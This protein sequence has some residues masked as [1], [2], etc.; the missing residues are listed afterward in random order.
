MSHM[1]AFFGQPPESWWWWKLMSVF[2]SKFVPELPMTWS[3]V[4]CF[5][6]PSSQLLWT[7]LT[8]VDCWSITR[9]IHVDPDA[10]EEFQH[11]EQAEH[12][13]LYLQT[14]QMQS[15]MV[16]F[17]DR[18]LIFPVFNF[19]QESMTTW[20]PYI[21]NYLYNA[22]YIYMYISSCYRICKHTRER[23]ALNILEYLGCS[24]RLLC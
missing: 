15:R 7:I 19:L 16:P 14:G 20:H 5:R 8:T 23:T 10:C 2:Q 18:H 21:V 3:F 1:C 4:P 6:D 24:L 13:F 12:V 9:L 22:H 11:G 17:L